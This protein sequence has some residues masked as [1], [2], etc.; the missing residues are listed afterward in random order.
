MSIFSK[1]TDS[2]RNVSYDSSHPKPCIDN[3]SFCLAK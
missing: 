3:I 1:P 2:K